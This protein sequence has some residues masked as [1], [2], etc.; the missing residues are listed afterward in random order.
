MPSSILRKKRLLIPK[1]L[2]ILYHKRGRFGN[3]DVF[4]PGVKTNLNN[5]CLSIPRV[6]CYN[7]RDTQPRRL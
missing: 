7:V 4:G 2:R 1:F 5:F 3:L 6:K